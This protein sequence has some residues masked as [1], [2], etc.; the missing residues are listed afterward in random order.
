MEEQVKTKGHG[1]SKT[2]FVVSPDG[3]YYGI[4]NLSRFCR[5]YGLDR[6]GMGNVV[7]GHRA[8]CQGWTKG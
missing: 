4:N 2:Y 1:N 6:G 3:V 8:Q 7:N 5:K